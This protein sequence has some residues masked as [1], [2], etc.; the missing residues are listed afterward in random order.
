VDSTLPGSALSVANACS[1]VGEVKALYHEMAEPLRGALARLAPAG[2]DVDDL[3]QEVFVVALR[4][5]GALLTAVSPKA[6]LYGVAVKVASAART[7]HK[8]R[9]FFGL[10]SAPDLADEASGPHEALSRRETAA[11][12]HAAL[13]GLTRKRREALV[14]FELEGLTGPEIAQALDIPLKTVWTRLHH[15]RKDFE[16]AVAL[17]PEM[18]R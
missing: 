13:S 6:W 2:G 8:L 12:V 18:S 5:S 1:E 7:R 15:A 11:R 3:L 14:L 16:A 10:E 4:R 17:D 9:S